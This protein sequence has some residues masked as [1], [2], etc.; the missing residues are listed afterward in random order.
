MN[1]SRILAVGLLCLGTHGVWAQVSQTLRFEIP[2]QED[3]NNDF[4]VVSTNE[5]GLILYRRL[6]GR[7]GDQMELIRLDTSL[8]ETWRGYIELDKNVVVVDTE[9]RQDFFFMLYRNESYAASDFKIVAI[10]IKNGQYGTYSVKNLIPFLA[11]EFRLTNDAALIGGYF[12][13]RPLILH[14]SFATRQSKILPGFFN[15]PGELNQVKINPNGSI[16]VVVSAKN[17][18]RKKSLWIRN[19]SDDGELIKTTILQPDEKKNLIFGRSLMMADGQQIVSGVYGRFK[20]YSRGIFIAAVSETGEYKINYYNFADLE[21]FF[22]YM[23]A[24]RKERVKGRI[25]RRRI[26]GKKLKFNYRFLVHELVKYK[27]QYVLLGEAFYPHYTYLSSYRTG[28]LIPS[29]Y[30]NP[31]VRGGLVFDGY[32]YTHAAVIGFNNEGKL[33]WD[34]SFEINDI[35][36]PT[37]EQFVKLQPANG[38]LTL[39]YVLDNKI[40]TKIIDNSNIL[41]GKSFDDIKLKF[42][43]DYVKDDRNKTNRL[44]YWYDKWLFAYGI[45][46]VKNLRDLSVSMERK[47]FFINKIT[48][49]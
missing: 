14:Y 7:R 21:H 8:N 4:N 2:L 42:Q 5:F 48:Y 31:L 47:V 24:N 3:D 37:L 16:D 23:K 38:K 44:D 41:E 35:K 12:N 13:Y 36:S 34:N 19:Y 25:E 32:Q 39:L 49:E 28:N 30:S 43:N 18:D 1:W 46:R 6:V 15:E 10:D 17:F 27:D 20:E 9:A 29:Y 40:R 45:Q 33:L 11:T 26:K 22:N